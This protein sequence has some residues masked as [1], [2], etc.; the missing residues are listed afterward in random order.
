MHSSNRDHVGSLLSALI[1]E[2]PE[3]EVESVTRLGEGME[4][5]AFE[6]NGKLIVRFSKEPKPAK[7]AALVSHEARL[8]ETVAG[9]STLPVPEPEFAVPDQG[10]LAY[11]KLPGTPLLDIPH[12]QRSA[13]APSIGSTLGELLAALHSVPVGR[14]A[15]LVDTDVQPLDDWRADAADLVDELGDRVPEAPRPAI[16]SFLAAVPPAPPSSLVFSHND[17]GIE[18]VLV[19]PADGT[20]TGIIDWGDS[21]ITDPAYDFGLLYRDLGPAAL[22]AALDSYRQDEHLGRIRGRAVFYGRCSVFEDLAYGIEIGDQR[23][24]GKALAAFT[25]LFDP[26]NLPGGP[27]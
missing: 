23:Y 11:F 20:V 19:D 2:M 26:G 24:V 21:A 14:M 17:L 9:I 22:E 27:I 3:L 13:Y 12:E 10:C 7:R 8:L 25:W 15:D 5:V 16:A 1:S 6:V 18:H 4:N